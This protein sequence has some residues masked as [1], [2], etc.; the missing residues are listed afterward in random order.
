MADCRIVADLLDKLQNP[1]IVGLCD[2]AKFRVYSNSS[3]LLE[4]YNL[5]ELGDNKNKIVKLTNL[6]E[7]L[8]I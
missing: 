3:K 6:L 1:D 5:A 8:Y 2:R 4:E 7:R